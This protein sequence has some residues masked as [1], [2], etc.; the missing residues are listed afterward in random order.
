MKLRKFLAIIKAK[1]FLSF[2]LVDLIRFV[3]NVIVACK[4]TEKFFASKITMVV[5][6][7]WDFGGLGEEIKR[8]NFSLAKLSNGNNKETG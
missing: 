1:N 2:M 4:Y 5:H 6:D 3:K 8:S 7:V